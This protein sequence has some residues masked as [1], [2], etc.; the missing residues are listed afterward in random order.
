MAKTVA[1]LTAELAKLTEAHDVMVKDA[2]KKKTTADATIEKLKAANTSLKEGAKKQQ[3]AK[4]EADKTGWKE[5]IR[6]SEHQWVQ[7]FNKGLADGVDFTFTFENLMFR[8]ISGEAVYLSVL[9]I[10]HLKLC[11][12]PQTKLRQG[13]AGTPVKHAGYHHNFNV[14]NC[15]PPIKEEQPDPAEEPAMA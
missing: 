14:V 4:A 5:K 10:N 8:L 3:K 15:E 2:E 12:R 6:T 11:R 7:V 13:E 9:V 1:E